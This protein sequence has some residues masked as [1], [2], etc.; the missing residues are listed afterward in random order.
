MY[1]L[2]ADDDPV[3]RTIL[4]ELLTGWDFEVTVVTNGREALDAIRGDPAIR[5][6]VLDWMMP[7]V[8]GFEV[9]RRL[10]QDD[11]RDI[12]V[13]LVT[14]SRNRKQII[15]VLVAGADDYLLKPFESMDLKIRLRG[16]LRIIELENEVWRLR[17]A[18]A[19]PLARL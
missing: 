14:G 4:K 3:Y 19:Q 17:G 15:R 8:N 5:L 6:A 16:A 9:C 13:I 7:E 12:Y 1:V 2:I 11:A 10:K 18:T